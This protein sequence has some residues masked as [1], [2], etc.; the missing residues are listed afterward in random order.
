MPS[1]RLTDG[2]EYRKADQQLG[3]SFSENASS[4][5]M[6]LGNNRSC[7]HFIHLV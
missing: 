6:A 1:A 4:R 3:I 5:G 7:V 2:F